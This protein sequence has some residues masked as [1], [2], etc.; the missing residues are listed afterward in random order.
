MRTSLREIFSW[1]AG[2]PAWG[3]ALVAGLGCGLPLLLGLFS[4][5]PGFLWASVGA[6]QAAQANPM[7]RLGM[8]RMLMLC[9]LGA[10]SAGLGF[11]VADQHVYSLF[12]FA[13]YGFLLAWLQRFGSEA[14]K[15][16]VGL[17]ICLCL[18]QAQQSL[19]AMN[20]PYAAA[21]LF[22]L[23]GL[24]VMLLAFF[25]RGFHGLR[26]W[27]HI[28]RLRSL[29]KVLRQHAKRMPQHKWRLHAL[30]C[31]L[32]FAL[33]GLVVNLANLHRGYW[34]TITVL[35]TLQLEFKGSLVRAVQSTLAGLSAAGLLILLGHSLQNP[36]M[37]ISLVLPLIVLS[38]ALQ[39]NH[40]GLF[41]AQ[42]TI[43]FVL[44]A[45]SLSHDWHLPAIRLFNSLL[46]V[47]I[48]LTVALFIYG[49]ARRIEQRQPP[50]PAPQNEQ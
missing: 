44:L 4:A 49:L 22:I 14:G 42:T 33:S 40:Y 16:G 26:M 19:G 10:L 2:P 41:V 45:E 31:T 3:A 47:A 23:G 15:L 9:M 7:H 29:F 24:W 32:A 34:L 11:W 27:P 17:A 48:G 38:R 12:V 8:L 30:G 1:H 36:V 43:C 25:L 13:A 35:S 5:H 6:F 39:A 37:M 20:S 46:G 18:G 28:P 50:M 21:M